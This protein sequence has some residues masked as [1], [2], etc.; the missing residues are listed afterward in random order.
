MIGESGVD[1]PRPIFTGC[2]TYGVTSSGASRGTNLQSN[3][4]ADVFGTW[5]NVGAATSRDY[6]GLMVSHQAQNINALNARNFVIEAGFGG[7]ALVRVLAN[8]DTVENWNI[9]LNAQAVVRKVAAGT[10][11]Q[12][13]IACALG[14]QS[15]TP[16]VAFHCFY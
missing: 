5:T 1:V 4:T 13:R 14:G 12:A 10:Q 6:R 9:A 8:T 7:A 3:V 15:Q 16:S 2:D 11:L